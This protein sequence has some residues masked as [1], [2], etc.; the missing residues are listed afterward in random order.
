MFQNDEPTLHDLLGRN[1]F[2]ERVGREISECA[3]PQ[4]FG[5]HGDWGL[6]KTSFM[7]ALHFY[8]A[9]E[10]PESHDWNKDMKPPLEG[11]GQQSHVRVVWFEAWRYQH[12]PNPIVALLQEIRT[13]LQWPTRFWN[14]AKKLGEVGV[15]GAL[16]GME[17]IEK[18]IGV[19]PS[20]VH[21]AGETWERKNY[22]TQLPTHVIRGLLDKAISEL[23]PKKKRNKT[24]ATPKLVI[25]IDDLDRC[26]SAMAY[27]LLEGIKIYLS[28]SNCVFVLGMDQHFIE[29]A[30]KDHLPICTEV[31]ARSALA[32]EYVEKICRC[33][34]HLPIVEEP[35]DLL[36]KILVG[37]DTSLDP[38]KLGRR[39]IEQEVVIGNSKLAVSMVAIA[40]KC[41]PGNPR[42]I[43]AYAEVLR[44]FMECIPKFEGMITKNI[45][46][47]IDIDPKIDPETGR[48]IPRRRKV[49]YELPRWAVLAVAFASL[50]HFHRKLYRILEAEPAFFQQIVDWARLNM[51]QADGDK[52]RRHFESLERSHMLESRDENESNPD[53]ERWISEF[54]DPMRGDIMRIGNL[55]SD[56]GDT[57]VNEV[58]E[59]ILKYTKSQS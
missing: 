53:T 16:F 8:L 25:L 38:V 41:L 12:E 54:A 28:L 57:T 59:C 56:I 19:K 9:G 31:E 17:S 55:L 2:V 18:F 49:V 20:E 23:L 52:R 13:Q 46:G 1:S 58:R 39:R 26:E 36:H 24:D 48:E 3:A 10:C 14:E 47:L 30:V 34:W 44:R 32:S 5:I 22:A 4:V 43:K 15:Y 40:Y 29:L 45:E 50:Y 42:K 35:G 37:T 27:R 21:K 6:G 33:I 11:W 51:K 7:H